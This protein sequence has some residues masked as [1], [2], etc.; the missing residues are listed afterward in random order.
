MTV[1][2]IT[3]FNMFPKKMFFNAR[4]GRKSSL[5]I[6]IS[7]SLISNVKTHF[8]FQSKMAEEG[9]KFRGVKKKKKRFP[10]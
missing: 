9:E 7:A 2:A 3:R 6:L 10:S 8:I 5:G 1:D 4:E